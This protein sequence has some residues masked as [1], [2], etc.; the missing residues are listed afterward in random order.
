[1]FFQECLENT[2]M[3]GEENMEISS[4]LCAHT[5]TFSMKMLIIKNSGSIIMRSKFFFTLFSD[6][7]PHFFHKCLCM[8]LYIFLFNYSFF[9]DNFNDFMLFL[10]VDD[11]NFLL[12]L[13]D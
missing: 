8:F 1:M 3:Y 5:V 7:F 9:K 12:Q 6:F 10:C 11:D 13:S 4:L 2:E